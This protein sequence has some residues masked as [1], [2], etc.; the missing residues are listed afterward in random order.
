M[1]M[2]KHPSPAQVL[3]ENKART[4]PRIGSR[5]AF[6]TCWLIFM[7]AA[8]VAGLAMLPNTIMVYQ[9]AGVPN[10]AT[11]I[12][13][14]GIC[15]GGNILFTLAILRWWKW[16]FYGF[17]VSTLVALGVN[18][19]LGVQAEHALYGFMGVFVLYWALQLDGP[20]SAWQ[21]LR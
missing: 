17:A 12:G 10:V 11:F 1:A 18:F 5:H 8:N 7:L 21:R 6:L 16:G 2:K 19:Y 15:M 9:K 3:D 4:G 20:Y 14:Q 13:L